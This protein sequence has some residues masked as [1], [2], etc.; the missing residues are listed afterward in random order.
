MNTGL[1]EYMILLIGRSLTRSKSL[2]SIHLCMNPGTTPR[3]IE[4]L[5]KRVRCMPMTDNLKFNV[6]DLI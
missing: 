4:Y 6:S 3:I 5:H 1:T 2:L